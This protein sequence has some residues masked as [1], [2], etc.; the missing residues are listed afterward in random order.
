LGDIPGIGRLFQ[1]NITNREKKVL[2][3]FIRPRI[4]KREQDSIQ[5]TGGKYNDIRQYQLDWMRRQEYNARN[6]DTV[7]P[8]L[9]SSML[10]RPFS[11]PPGQPIMV[12][13]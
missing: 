5:V 3:V 6:K 2:M 13:K 12:T 10:P 9:Q 11:R 1:R 7:L 8:P 4:L